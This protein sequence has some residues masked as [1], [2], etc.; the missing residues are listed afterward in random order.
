M[1]SPHFHT[2]LSEP[3]GKLPDKPSMTVEAAVARA[4]EL[5]AR[6]PH[7]STCLTI[8][9]VDM[10]DSL[11]YGHEVD[12]INEA[13]EEPTV[14][15]EYSRAAGSFFGARNR[16]ACVRDYLGE[17]VDCVENA[18]D[19]LGHRLRPLE[20]VEAPEQGFIDALMA[21]EG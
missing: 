7:G 16:L 4:R 10:L 12:A 15:S 5:A 6:Y 11:L 20:L 13:F 8:A 19:K 21:D 2:T 1:A 14:H 17:A 9:A 18:E 3:I